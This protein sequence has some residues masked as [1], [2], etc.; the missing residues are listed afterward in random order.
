MQGVV[1]RRLA[2]RLDI[3]AIRSLLG[4]VLNKLLRI[5]AL[6]GN[7]LVFWRRRIVGKEEV[8]VVSIH[9]RYLI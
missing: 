9:Q 8:L 3:L 1:D 5:K 6:T 2:D 7:L 4:F